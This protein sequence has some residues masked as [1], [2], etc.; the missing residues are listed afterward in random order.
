MKQYVFIKHTKQSSV[1]SHCTQ[2]SN[3]CTAESQWIPVVQHP[4]M[5]SSQTTCPY[6]NDGVGYS[7]DD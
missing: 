1:S 4:S 2:S 6:D 7:R 3:N 5:A